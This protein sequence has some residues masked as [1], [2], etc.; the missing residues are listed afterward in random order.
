MESAVSHQRHPV[1]RDPSLARR[2]R[3]D[4]AV[5]VPF[6]EPAQVDELNAYV[7]DLGLCGE[8]G[9]YD[10]A[11]VDLDFA[12]RKKIHD[13]L[14]EAFE[15]SAS[16]LLV[17]YRPIMSSIIAKWPGPGGQK[18]IH[19]DF[20]MVDESRFR[21]VCIWVPLTDVDSS[22][23]ALAVLRGSHMVATG[24]R[25][26]PATPLLPKD[27]LPDLEFADLGVVKAAVGDAVVFDLAI[28]HGSAE[29]HSSRPRFAVGIAYAPQAAEISMLYCHQD[30]RIEKLAVPDPDVFRRIRW[31]ERPV[32][33]ASMGF[34]DERGP[35]VSANDLIH[36]SRQVA[37]G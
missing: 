14:C 37:N 5:V 30:D 28:V 3:A 10:T 24:P 7:A 4:G 19:R 22:N 20:Q 1:F 13:R 17:D 33:L 8:T 29:N 2:F 12:D 21:S 36:R 27:P 32:E 35:Q 18:E 6:L 31:S 23:G 15:Q 9:F 34:L 25:S 11:G 16:N 26:V